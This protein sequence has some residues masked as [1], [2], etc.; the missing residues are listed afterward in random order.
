MWYLFVLPF[1]MWEYGYFLSEHI[2][3]N[4]LSY[5]VKASSYQNSFTIDTDIF[6]FGF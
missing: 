3:V 1:E 6:F 4:L 5:F 2:H